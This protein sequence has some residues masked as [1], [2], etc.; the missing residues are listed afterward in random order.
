VGGDFRVMKGK[1][2]KKDTVVT[3]SELRKLGFCPTLYFFDVHIPVSQPLALRLRAW[4]GRLAH[5]I[6]HILRPGW[7]KEELLRARVDE[8]D[9]V[10]VGKPDSYRINDAS[11]TLI[12]EEF[13]SRKAPRFESPCVVNGV[14]L[15]DALQVMAY[16]YILSKIHDVKIERIELRLRYINK[17]VSLRYDNDL[18][19]KYLKLLKDVRDG[20]FPE[21]GW[22]SRRKCRLCPY[23]EVCPYSPFN[24]SKDLWGE[25]DV[26]PSEA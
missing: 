4:L 14:W 9:V 2:N 17:T 11:G 21:P 24:V 8:L 15:G 19:V 22:V 18:L 6:H 13:K 20:I 23:K 10:L 12:V 3:P 25:R 26:N 5:A 16:A 1:Q 7:V